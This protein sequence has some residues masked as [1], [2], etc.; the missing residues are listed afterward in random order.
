MRRQLEIKATAKSFK[1]LSSGLYSDKIRAVIRELATNARDGHVKAARNGDEEALTR[2]FEVYIPSYNNP[3]F[4]VR[5]FGVG[6][7]EEEIYNLYLTYFD[8]DKADDPDF[9]GELGLGSKSPLAYTENEFYTTSYY[10]GTKSVYHIFYDNDGIPCVEKT[11]EEPTDEHNGL[12]VSITVRPRDCEHFRQKAENILSWHEVRP[13]VHSSQHFCYPDDKFVVEKDDYSIYADRQYNGSYIVMGNVAYPLN[14]QRMGVDDTEKVIIDHG[15]IIRVPSKAVTVTASREELEYTDRTIGAIRDV[16]TKIIN[17]LAVEVQQQINAC[18]TL[19][20]ARA[21]LYEIQRSFLSKAVASEKEITWNGELLT[22]HVKCDTLNIH[23]R[24]EVLRFRRKRSGKEVLERVKAD[25]IIGDGRFVFIND[26]KRGSYASVER[27]M[28]E[29]QI[30]AVHMITPS[31]CP[32]ED[33]Q[34]WCVSTG[35]VEVLKFAS[36]LPKPP[37][38]PRGSREKREYA[39]VVRLVTHCDNNYN[40]SRC[41]HNEENIDL[42]RGGIYVEIHRYRFR[43]VSQD[44]E[45]DHPYV[46]SD[47][48]HDLCRVGV[49]VPK[50]YGVRSAELPM[51]MKRSNW[52]SFEEFAK[53]TTRRFNKSADIVWRRQEWLAT[54]LDENIVAY[55]IDNFDNHSPFRKLIEYA[56]N[57]YTCKNNTQAVYLPRVKRWGG[58]SVPEKEYDLEQTWKEAQDHYPMLQL[59]SLGYRNDENRAKLIT[60]YVQMIDAQ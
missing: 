19:W 38:A 1:I 13:V 46:L 8:S 11:H 2:P 44:G 5:D 58:F 29:N 42:N 53:R 49:K 9:T 25:Y 14:A 40:L 32:I 60:N 57:A 33:L 28:R 47:Y 50:I 16:L 20:Q 7:S 3:R 48:I 12:K 6:L 52:I 34:E 51:V 22:T 15:V 55:D 35:M 27:F 4:T 31:E 39:P 43:L 30:K 37:R 45:Y 26:Q 36:K 10:N 41:W 21:K 18:P 59:C 23:P 17:D 54:S 56:Q 24:L